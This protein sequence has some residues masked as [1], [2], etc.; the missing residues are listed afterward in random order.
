M[1]VCCLLH[2][3]WDCLTWSSCGT[4]NNGSG[5][6]YYLLTYSWDSFPSAGFPCPSLIYVGLL[7]V[8]EHLVMPC[9]VDNPGS[10][11][12]LKTKEKWIWERG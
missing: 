3:C 12:F 4:P 7:P 6:V 8:L 9:L 2:T 1:L 11:F 5:A 10:A